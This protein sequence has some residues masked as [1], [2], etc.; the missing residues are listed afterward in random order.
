MNVRVKIRAVP[1]LKQILILVNRLLTIQ[2]T[3]FDITSKNECRQ[4]K[5]IALS[6]CI[7]VKLFAPEK[8]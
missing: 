1:S 4:K 7:T 8:S 3:D 5:V 2:N 6:H